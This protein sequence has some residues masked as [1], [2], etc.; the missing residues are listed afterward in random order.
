MKDGVVPFLRRVCVYRRWVVLRDVCGI[1][2]PSLGEPVM[3][4]S[5]WNIER[6]HIALWRPYPEDWRK[7]PKPFQAYKALAINLETTLAAEFN[8]GISSQ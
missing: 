3:P 1:S 6:P 2:R 5:D 4:F 8:E 7:Q